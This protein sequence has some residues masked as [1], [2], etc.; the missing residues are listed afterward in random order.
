MSIN[1]NLTRYVMDGLFVI[2]IGTFGWV[3]NKADMRVEKHEIRIQAAE[4]SNAKIDAK[5]DYLVKRVDEIKD[6]IKKVNP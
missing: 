6:D 1:G 3:A 4:I 5:L 2:L